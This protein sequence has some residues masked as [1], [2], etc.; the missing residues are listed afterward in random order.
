M[1]FNRLSSRKTKLKSSQSSYTKKKLLKN[2]VQGQEV[3]SFK[4]NLKNGKKP[5]DKTQAK[6]QLRERPY[7]NS[8]TF[9]IRCFHKED[10]PNRPFI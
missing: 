7:H 10:N 5:K 1:F 9:K 2:Q 8:K 4:A 6:L 3:H